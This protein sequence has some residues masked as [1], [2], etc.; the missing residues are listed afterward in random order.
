MTRLLL[1]AA[2]AIALVAPAKAQMKQKDI[3]VLVAGLVFYDVKCGGLTPHTKDKMSALVAVAD[4]K[5][6]DSE[7]SRVLN[8]V[9][10]VGVTNWCNENRPA[11]QQMESR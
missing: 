3:A 9:H 7:A 8:R 10:A 5:L 4:P 2:L 1:S 6:V 11:I